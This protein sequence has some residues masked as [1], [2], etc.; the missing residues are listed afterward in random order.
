MLLYFN[1]SQQSYEAHPCSVFMILQCCCDYSKYVFYAHKITFIVLFSQIWVFAWQQTQNWWPQKWLWKLQ[2]L[3]AQIV[4][5]TGNRVAREAVINKATSS[6]HRTTHLAT[7][8]HQNRAL[9][10]S[11]SSQC[12]RSSESLYSWCPSSYSVDVC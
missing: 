1:W 9:V 3:L 10:I 11:I 5:Q 8:Y 6:T 7:C 4:V 12:L 2:S